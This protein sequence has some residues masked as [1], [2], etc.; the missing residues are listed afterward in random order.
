MNDLRHWSEEDATDE[1]RELLREHRV[2]PDPAR[3]RRIA[4]ALGVGAIATTSTAAAGAVGL[5]AK[6]VGVVAIG[7][8]VAG[9]AYWATRPPAPVQPPPPIASAAVVALPVPPPPVVESATVPPAPTVIASA[10]VVP[11]AAPRKAPS[12]PPAS[13]SLTREVATLGRA[14]SALAAHDPDGAMRALDEYRAE[15]PN[16]KMA[17]EETV[18]RVQVLMAKGQRTQ[19][20]ALADAFVAEHPDSPFASQVQRLVAK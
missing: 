4:A 7:G 14:R 19:A 17:S 2:R 6:I 20:K 1:E 15:F 8:A 3:R 12:A 11:S 10:P 18:L 13:S 9:G 5:A 16:G